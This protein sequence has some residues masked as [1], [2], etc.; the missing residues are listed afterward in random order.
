MLFGLFAIAIAMSAGAVGGGRLVLLLLLLLRGM[1]VKMPLQLSGMGV[2]PGRA[3]C[4]IVA[5]VQLHLCLRRIPR[6]WGWKGALQKGRCEGSKQVK[7][8]AQPVLPA[9]SCPR[10]PLALPSCCSRAHD[11]AD[12][13]TLQ[14]RCFRVSTA[15]AA[16]LLVWNLHMLLLES[17][18]VPMVLTRSAWR[19]TA[20]P[21][22]CCTAAQPPPTRSPCTDGRQSH[23]LELGA[24]SGER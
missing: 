23:L 11:Q 16:L 4:T 21:V 1:G 3:Y 18:M 22:H 10:T 13:V 6:S 15:S 8:S 17:G 5:P 9:P 12:Q 24:Y 20:F 19:S 7:E 2:G 14:E